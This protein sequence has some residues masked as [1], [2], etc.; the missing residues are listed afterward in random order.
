MKS[1]SFVPFMDLPQNAGIKFELAVGSST[2][3]REELRR[4]GWEVRDPLEPTRT[5][6]TYQT[7]IKRSKA[8][9]GIA[10]HGYV[11]THSGWF[12]ERSANYLASGRPVV[13]QDTGFTDWLHADMGVKSFRT[14]DEALAAIDDVNSRY[15]AHCRAAREVAEAYFDYRKVLSELIERAMG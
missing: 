4:K 14:P 15:E 7:Y 8:E 12:S 13:V 1:E 11:V 5:P 6:W 10:K 2:A 3:P 9:F